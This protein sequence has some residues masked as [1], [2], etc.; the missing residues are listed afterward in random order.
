MSRHAVL[1][2]GGVGLAL[3]AALA[4]G[5]ED[6]TLL[7]RPASLARYGGSVTVRQGLREGFTV[8]VPAAAH[9]T[10]PIDVLWVCVKHPDLPGA[11]STVAADVGVVVPLLN[12][13][14][15]LPPLRERFG[16]RVVA[17][18][19]RIEAT[20][21]AVG[22]VRQES[23]FT[24]IELAG[25]PEVVAEA[26]T[27]AG[28][29]CTDGGSE[30][31]VLWRKLALLAPLALA[32]TC[33]GG[34]LDAVREDEDLTRLMLACA[35]EACAS[36]R[37]E[38]ARLDRGRVLRALTRAPGRTRTSLQR[39]VER[40]EAGELDAIA[41]PVREAGARHAIPTPATDELVH[42]ARHDAGTPLPAGNRE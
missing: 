28:I 39:D 38:G 20:R 8:A 40:G 1:G 35:D 2:A 25:P 27:A 13:T 36:G 21:T 41:G 4:R 26:L 6:V 19:I 37:A 14:G 34:P 15:H 29:G 9:L 30:A 33:A 7:L 12:G 23:L 17:G 16:D 3:A 5:G 42:R 11:L 22:E 32:T 31:D 10:G 24:E 18:S